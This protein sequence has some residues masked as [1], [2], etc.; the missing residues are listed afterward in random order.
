[1]EGNIS[2]FINGGISSMDEIP[3][4]VF[5]FDWRRSSDLKYRHRPEVKAM[6][7]CPNLTHHLFL[8]ERWAKNS[9]YIFK[10]LEKQ[11]EHFVYE[12][13]VSVHKIKVYWNTAMLSCLYIIHKAAF[14][15]HQQSREGNR[16]HMACKAKLFTNSF[17]SGKSANFWYI[18]CFLL[19]LLLQKKI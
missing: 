6:A 14:K 2:I 19:T 8:Y 17:F 12:I 18:D 4:I 10:Q 3:W 13:Q 5:F 1:M 7:H 11:E 9:F 16:D 15:L